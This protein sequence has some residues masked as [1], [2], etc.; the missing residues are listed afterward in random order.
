MATNDHLSCVNV[1]Y[2]F[3]MLAV[4][5]LVRHDYELYN[6]RI[7]CERDTCGVQPICCEF[8]MLQIDINGKNDVHLQEEFGRHGV[9]YPYT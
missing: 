9:V 5:P 3:V 6:N 7:I 4:G 2:M 1:C 8:R